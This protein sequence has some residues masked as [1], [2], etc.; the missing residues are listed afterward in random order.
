MVL[1]AGRIANPVFKGQ[2]ELG[3]GSRFSD[4]DRKAS[5]LL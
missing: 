1:G 3:A 2:K 5:R 4:L